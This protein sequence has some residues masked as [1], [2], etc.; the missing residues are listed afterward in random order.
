M[1]L[2]LKLTYLHVKDWKVQINC[3]IWVTSILYLVHLL[4]RMMEESNVISD[5]N[6]DY[7]SFDEQ[8]DESGRPAERW[9]PLGAAAD[10]K[11]ST[12][13]AEHR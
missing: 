4:I 7:D 9:A 2:N 12:P 1:P 6:G 10:P 11:P 3:H 13:I 5:D 8:N